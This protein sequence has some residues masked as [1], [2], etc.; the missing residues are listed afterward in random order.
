MPGNSQMDAGL[1]I[2]RRVEK[3]W[4]YQ[5]VFAVTPWYAGGVDVIKEGHSLSLQYHQR[6][7]ETLYLHQGKLQVEL[8]D[9]T[10]AMNAF[11]LGPGQSVRFCPRQKHRV[12]ALEDSVIFEVS[13]PQ[14]DDV[15]RLEDRYG[16]AET[17]PDGC[18]GQR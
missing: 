13:T 4:G 9:D 8:E 18:A 7:D 1:Q 6:R 15:V 16:R 2:V 14:M 12:T 10:G 5:L 3:P 11:Q 17:D